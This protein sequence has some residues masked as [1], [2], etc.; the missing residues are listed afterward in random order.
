MK[1]FV[2]GLYSYVTMFQPLV[3]LL[4]AIALVVV[5]ILFILPFE[6]TKEAAKSAVPWIMIGAGMVL[7][8]GELA[9]EFCNKLTFDNNVPEAALNLIIQNVNLM[10][11]KMPIIF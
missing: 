10:C 2:N 3:N 5:G 7:G 4:V 9:R 1:N 11:C 8:A 6:K